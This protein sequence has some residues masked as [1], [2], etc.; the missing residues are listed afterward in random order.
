MRSILLSFLLL[1]S[2]I[3]TAQRPMRQMRSMHPMRPG[4]L[5]RELPEL[6]PL[7]KVEL[8][9]A[10][11]YAAYQLVKRDW[12]DAD[13]VGNGGIVLVT[14]DMYSDANKHNFCFAHGVRVGGDPWGQCWV[15]HSVHSST[16]HPRRTWDCARRL[17]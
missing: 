11:G 10:G 4:H 1:S 5:T 16:A 14:V 17:C 12:R 2:T 3:A 13:V 8:G 15:M 6:P 7:P 9:V